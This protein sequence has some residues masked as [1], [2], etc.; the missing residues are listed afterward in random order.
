[1]YLGFGDVLYE[2]EKFSAAEKFYK[3][4]LEIDPKNE[5]AAEKLKILDKKAAAAG[6]RH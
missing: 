5:A 6:A 3:K 1:M 2:Q 4:A